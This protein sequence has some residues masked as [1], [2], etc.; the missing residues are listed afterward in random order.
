MLQPLVMQGGE[1]CHKYR[2][3]VFNG[4]FWGVNRIRAISRVGATHSEKIDDWNVTMIRSWMVAGI[5]GLL[6]SCLAGEIAVAQDN[7]LPTLPAAL[8][9]GNN[10][11]LDQDDHCVWVDVERPRESRIICSD[12]SANKIFV[13]DMEGHVVQ[14]L[15]VPHPGNI[16]IRCKVLFSSG[17]VYDIVVVNRREPDPALLGFL[18]NKE[19]GT[20]QPLE[21]EIATGENYGGC[22]FHDV[23]GR[24]LYAITTSKSGTIE[25]YRIEV[26]R[27]E[28]FKG[29]KSRTWKIEYC[30]GAVADDDSGK[31]Y[32]AE[33]NGSIWKLDA[34]PNG[35]L[36]GDKLCRVGE[37]GL[38]GNL[39]GLALLHSP[40]TNKKLLLVSDQG[41]SRYVLLSTEFPA[42]KVLEF[43]LERGEHTDGIEICQQ[44]LGAQFPSGLMVSHTDSDGKM[45]IVVDLK[46]VLNLLK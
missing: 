45:P 20:L 30:E 8:R 2:R 35:S 4:W 25:Q 26:E 7:G 19:Q 29:T 6:V 41:R 33:E 13:Y 18:V 16:D 31:L 21:G 10:R 38:Q 36:P 40:V 42:Q 3:A 9:L 28:S 23:K 14:A 12:K 43:A 37:L 34:S 5:S 39:E 32:I 22:L 24:A 15:D 1:S 46:K 27:N 17:A 44:P 11:A